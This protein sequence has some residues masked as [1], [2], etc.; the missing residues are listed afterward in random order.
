MRRQKATADGHKLQQ[1]KI[2]LDTGKKKIFIVCVESN[3]GKET[4]EAEAPPFLMS[5]RLLDKALSNLT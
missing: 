1:E 3:M 2:L 4:R 5:K